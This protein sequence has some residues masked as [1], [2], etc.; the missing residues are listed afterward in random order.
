M[1]KID[2]EGFVRNAFYT[3]GMILII[4]YLIL[5]MSN[6]T[7]GCIVG[8]VIVPSMDLG[9]AF[10]VISI[11]G[12]AVTTIGLLAFLV[13]LG[14]R[15][16]NKWNDCIIPKKYR[17]MTDGIDMETEFNSFDKRLKFDNIKEIRK[18]RGRRTYRMSFKTDEAGY[19]FMDRILKE[20]P[21]RMKMLM[22]EY[23][24][25]MARILKHRREFKERSEK[26]RENIVI[27]F[28][29]RHDMKIREMFGNLIE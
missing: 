14:I 7:A 6:I 24:E 23:P 4:S 17:I 5:L 11:F 29:P 21:E 19:E 28:I 9:T 12:A 3:K 25:R 22:D 2:D 26:E 8:I 27:S 10:A 18:L 15:W 13:F 20:D 1:P 16:V